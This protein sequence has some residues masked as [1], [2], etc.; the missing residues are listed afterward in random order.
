MIDGLSDEVT[1]DA[2]AE[3]CETPGTLSGFCAGGKSRQCRYAVEARKRADHPAAGPPLACSELQKRRAG[4][5][6][7]TL[8]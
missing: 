2:A 5:G 1:G 8:S 6:L 4:N 3:D 7:E